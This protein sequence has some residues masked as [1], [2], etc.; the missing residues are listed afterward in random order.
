MDPDLHE[1]APWAAGLLGMTTSGEIC[2]GPQQGVVPF[3]YADGVAVRKTHRGRPAYG[4]VPHGKTTLEHRH[5][6]LRVERDCEGQLQAHPATR[7]SRVHAPSAW[8]SLTIGSAWV[9]DP[10]KAKARWFVPKLSLPG[11]TGSGS[12]GN[13]GRRG[14]RR[15]E[16]QGG[17]THAAR[18]QSQ[19]TRS[20]R[21]PPGCALGPGGRRTRQQ[22]QRAVTLW[23]PVAPPARVRARL[24]RSSSERRTPSHSLRCLPFAQAVRPGLPTQG[25]CWS[26]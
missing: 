6:G 2:T 9:T 21:S 11:R 5:P 13:G 24:S 26:T 18:V 19:S 16:H 25:L 14:P 17:R 1:H 3:F 10:E 22:R 8:R 15:S 20:P 12:G 23:N 4:R 7:A